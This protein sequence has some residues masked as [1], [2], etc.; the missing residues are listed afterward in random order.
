MST[1]SITFHLT[2]V[3]IWRAQQDR[4]SYEPEAFAREGFIHCTDG[5]SRVIEVGNR[6]YTG[7][8]REFCLLTLDRAKISAPTIYEDPEQV[9]PHIYGPLNTDAVVE[10]RCVL[11]IEGGKFVGIGDRL[12]AS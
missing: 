12:P 10:V 1:N 11:R 7:D 4:P 6:Y 9:Y 5:E 2:P 8:P 3:D